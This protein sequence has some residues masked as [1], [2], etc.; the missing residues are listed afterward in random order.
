L[1]SSPQKQKAWQADQVNK[2]HFFH[3]K[4]HEWGLLDVQDAIDQVSGEELAW[5]TPEERAALGISESAWNKIIHQGI[6]PVK[7][8][9][10]PGVLMS[11]SRSVGYY[12]MLSMV[13]QKSTPH[14]GVG[15]ASYETGH[16][17][18]TIETAFNIAAQLNLIICQLIE[19]D[20][21][22]DPREFDL[23]RGMAAGSQAQGSWQNRKGNIGEEL[24]R[25]IVRRRIEEKGLAHET[26]E[27]VFNINLLD[28][29][30]IVFASDPDIAIY[31]NNQPIVA[32]EI[33]GGID[34]AGVHE[35]YGAIGKSFEKP[36]RANP[37]C[38]TIL[39]IQSVS[40]TGT[41]EESIE[42]NQSIDYWFTL[43]DLLANAAK[44]EEFLGLLKI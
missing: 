6:K 12:R 4:L 16:R 15:T 25:S 7:V 42:D 44:R 17:L 33:K 29:R 26:G 5:H 3:Q 32:I 21:S 22:I 38:V 41:A 35:R 10:H 13:S 9:A 18:P 36:K 2:S 27:E 11:L 28:G 30:M 34:T 40:L 8:F 19:T 37:A 31:A 23:W 24:V 43:E 39:V 14:A 20:E 1:S